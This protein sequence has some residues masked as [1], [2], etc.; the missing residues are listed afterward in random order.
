[1]IDECDGHSTAELL[2]LCLMTAFA[3]AGPAL[4]EFQQLLLLMSFIQKRI[5]LEHTAVAAGASECCR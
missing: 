2:T 4:A 1:M 5:T 3:K